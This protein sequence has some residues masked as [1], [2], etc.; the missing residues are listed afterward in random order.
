MPLEDPVRVG[1]DIDV[2][3]HADPDVVDLGLIVAGGDPDVSGADVKQRLPGVDPIAWV[4]LPA[5]DVAGDLGADLGPAQLEPGIV[6]LL[7]GAGDGGPCHPDGW[8][9]LD[10]PFQT[11]VG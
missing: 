10:D 5:L 6:E 11:F 8:S 7:L 3:R 9:L 2:D 4:D 1:V